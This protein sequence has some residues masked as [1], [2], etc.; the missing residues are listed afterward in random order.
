M[1]SK[2]PYAVRNLSH[3]RPVS[4][5]CLKNSELMENSSAAAANINDI[6]MALILCAAFLAW[7]GISVHCQ[8]I[9][10]CSGRGLSYKKYFISK[11]IQGI[12][13]SFM[14]GVAIKF[15]FPDIALESKDVFMTE[16]NNLGNINSILSCV[17][18]FFASILSGIFCYKKRI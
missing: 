16:S 1:I 6:N 2:T 10:I 9:A 15:L 18:F 8:I 7:S 3:E 17:S 14:M 4:S 5:P 12:L 11:A 13:C